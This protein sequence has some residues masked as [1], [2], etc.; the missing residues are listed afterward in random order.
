MTETMIRTTCPRDCYD[1]CGI[2]VILNDGEIDRVTGDPEHPENRG[3]LCG[4]CTLAYNG[5]WRDPSARLL[6]PLRRTG[7]KGSDAFEEVSWDDALGEIAARLGGLIDAGRAHDILTAH[8]TGTCSVIANQFPMRFFNH[9]GATEVNPDSICNLSGHVALGYVLGES[10]T[11]FDPRTAKVSTCLIIWGGNPSASGPHVNKHWLAEFPGTLIVIDPIRT[12]TAA[13]ADIHLRPYPGTDATLAFG[14]MHALKDMGSLDDDFIA[15]NTVGFDELSTAIADWTPARAAG[16]TGI[17]EADIIHAA[18]AYGA[19]PSMLFLGQALCRA[20]T[21]GN[22]FRAAAMLPAITGNIGKPGTGLCFLNGKGTTRGLDMGY[23]GRADLRA[24]AGQ[25]ISHMDLRAAL[26]ETPVDKALFL[27]NI[28]VAASNPDQKRLLAALESD[29]LFTV[30]VDL[31]LTD[32]VRRADIVLP[33]ASFL[34]FDDL[35]GSY[36]H[37]SLGPQSKAAEPMGDALPN[38]EIFRRLARAM[39]LNEPALYEDDEQILNHLL[40]AHG[41]T[42]DELKESGTVYPSAS[43]VIL[44]EDLNFPTPTSKIELASTRAAADGHPLVPSAEPLARPAS[45]KVRLLTPAGQWHM[46][47]S[48]DNEPRIAAR[49]AEPTITLHPVDAEALGLAEGITAR[50]HNEAG[51]LSMRVAISEKTLP[52]V[53]WSPKGMWPGRGRDGLNVNA[54]NPGLRADMGD[55]TALHGVEVTLESLG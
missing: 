29:H 32:S 13:R 12:P 49:A 27:W 8:Y 35:V 43:P 22:A 50:V 6:R 20:P 36:F 39:E 21:G 37:L 15:R 34:E 48:Y 42:F 45:G 28:N 31:F 24:D 40:S 53:A 44:W 54:L 23:V 10:A 30:V 26:E 33:A 25:S 17:P 38:Q 14:M 46:N 51:A 41:L 3:S 52:G 55:S 5:V 18:E 19:G 9:I 7:P 2:R 16:V 4:K 1:G 47:S 11:G